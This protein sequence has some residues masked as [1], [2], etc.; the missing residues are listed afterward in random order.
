LAI[1]PERVALVELTSPVPFSDFVERFPS[2]VPTSVVAV[3]N[4]VEESES[5]P[6]G[7]AKRVV[8]R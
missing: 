2:T 4:Q 6:A 1:E 7:L 5:L 8:S 3:I